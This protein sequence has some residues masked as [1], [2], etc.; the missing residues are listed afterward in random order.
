MIWAESPCNPILRLTDIAAVSEI[1]HSAGAQ[2]TVD[3]TMATPVA[4]KPL[5][6]GA[7]FVVHSLTKYL[8]GHGDALGG[9]AIGRRDTLAKLRQVALVHFGGVL[10]PF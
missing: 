6:L 2:L 10:S 8:N 1:A 5:A 9:A 3:S 7:D 4:T